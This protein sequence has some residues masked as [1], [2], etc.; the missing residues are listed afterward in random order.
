MSAH[1]HE[2]SPTQRRWICV[3]GDTL[4]I[5]YQERRVLRG[6][7]AWVCVRF[8]PPVRLAPWPV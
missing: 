2:D 4:W 3:A 5:V 7:E 1:V 8:D 6:G